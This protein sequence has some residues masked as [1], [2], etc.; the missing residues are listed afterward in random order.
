MLC[1]PVDFTRSLVSDRPACPS[2]RR[3]A[4]TRE[5]PKYTQTSSLRFFPKQSNYANLIIFSVMQTQS[6]K[7]KQRHT[8]FY[9]ACLFCLRRQKKKLTV[10][11]EQVGAENSLIYPLCGLCI[12]K[13]FAV[14]YF[15][16]LFTFSDICFRQ[17]KGVKTSHCC[18]K[19]N[20]RQKM[21]HQ[22]PD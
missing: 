19:P 10:N 15:P 11:V 7:A 12:C 4:F 1:Q 5:L 22:N 20:R 14:V 16:L 6:R 9:F 13:S 21:F 3:T 8:T 2:L 17:L 18:F